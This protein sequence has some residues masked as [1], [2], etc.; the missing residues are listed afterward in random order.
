MKKINILFFI[1]TIITLNVNA[2][3]KIIS[4][5]EARLWTNNM[6]PWDNSMVTYAN[7]D[8]SKAYVVE[9]NGSHKFFVLGDG[10]VYARGSYIN[11]DKNLKKDIKNIK[12]INNLFRLQAKSYKFISTKDST[13]LMYKQINSDNIDTSFNGT[14]TKQYGFIAQEVKEVYPE[15]VSEDVEG[16]LSINYVALIP[17]IIEAAKQQKNQIETYK[18]LFILKKK[19]LFN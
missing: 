11:S 8:K 17:L 12:N 16:L 9:R 10:H 18:K 7:N 5:G 19:R 4:N 14:D 15:L 6:G 13:A 3:F 2:Q 1:L